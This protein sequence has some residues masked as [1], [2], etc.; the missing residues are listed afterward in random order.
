MADFLI[1]P[2]GNMSVS[3]GDFAVVS[4]RE[5]IRQQLRIRLLFFFGEWFRDISD[6][7]DYPG[8]ILARPFRS[9]AAAREIRRNVIRVDGLTSI[10]DVKFTENKQTQTVTVALT[11]RDRF[12]TQ[13]STIEVTS[14]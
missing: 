10:V 5:A 6:G 12:S 11:Y 13:P 2:D 1:D 3:G 4:G 9:S 8:E 7:V 14:P